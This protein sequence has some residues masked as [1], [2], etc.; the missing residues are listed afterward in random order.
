MIYTTNTKKL[1]EEVTR[2]YNQLKNAKNSEER[3]ALAN[4]IGN[5]Y[6]EISLVENEKVYATRKTIFGSH[7]NYHKF[8]KKLRI[9][10]I[11]TLENF[12]LQKDFHEDYIRNILIGVEDNFELIPEPGKVKT[13]LLNLEDF[14]AIFFDFMQHIGQE[15]L[16]DKFYKEERIYNSVSREKIDLLGTT[17][18]NPISGETNI[19]VG[20]FKYDIQTMKVLAH[21]FGHAYDF[22]R[23]NE[24]IE[25][26]N[27]Y[28]HQ[29]FYNEVFSRLFERLLLE[30]LINN[31]IL[32]D[33]AKYKLYRFN[34]I[35]QDYLL[36]SY[37]LSL[38]PDDY[39]LANAF[40]YD[41]RRQI[42]KKVKDNFSDE[43]SIKKF[44][45]EGERL[46]LKEDLTYAYGDIISM[47]LKIQ[48]DNYG[49]DNDLVE[50]IMKIRSSMFDSKIFEKYN[51]GPNRY[52]KLHRQ[53]FK[54]IKK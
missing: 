11:K 2:A 22:S 25:D 15:E 21:E 23:F 5:L 30:Y 18:Y 26:W 35:N 42:F 46:N 28:F 39:L 1:Y 7:R 40:Q 17:E 13:T 10:D 51:F 45:L 47:F 38:L 8:V 54:L 16:F 36:G 31:D 20:D 12:V 29:S 37:I 19:F 32:K 34:D 41:N 50:E 33:E 24:S 27:V 44:I 4:Y 48:I 6:V 52:K 14:Y 3:L 9:E 53:E 43:D 49:F